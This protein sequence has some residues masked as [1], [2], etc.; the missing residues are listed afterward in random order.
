MNLLKI[1]NTFRN[2]NSFINLCKNE[3]NFLNQCILSKYYLNPSQ[4]GKLLENSIKSNFNFKNTKDNFSGDC[5][6]NN[7]L[8]IE[9]KVSLGSFN[10][11]FNF[12]QI[13]PSHQIDYYLFVIYDC[14]IGIHGQIYY[15]LIPSKELYNLIPEYGGYSHGTITKNGKITKVDEKYE[16]SL[17]PNSLKPGKSNDLFKILLKYRVFPEQL[18]KL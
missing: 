10:G 1:V 18:K 12:V 6:T 14:Y 7:N 2:N 3:P 13:R 9:I 17:R 11:Q 16:Y 15:L 4:W 5:L 8:K